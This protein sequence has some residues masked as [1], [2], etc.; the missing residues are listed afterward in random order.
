MTNRCAS[1]LTGL[2][3]TTESPPTAC[4]AK[5][6][7]VVVRGGRRSDGSPSG[8]DAPEYVLG[9]GAQTLAM[10]EGAHTYLGQ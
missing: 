7:T 3:E 5:R 6:K 10:L 2:A 9:Y 8:S 1:E 4:G